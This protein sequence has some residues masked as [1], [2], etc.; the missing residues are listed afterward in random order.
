M[1]ARNWREMPEVG[2]ILIC[3]CSSSSS[4]NYAKE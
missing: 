4:R 1:D 3:S 2:Q